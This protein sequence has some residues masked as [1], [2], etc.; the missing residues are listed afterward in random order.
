ME[1]CGT[2]AQVAACLSRSDAVERRVHAVS[3]V[4][5]FE[6][7]EFPLEIRGIPKQDVIE[8]L[9]ADR[10]D[11]PFDKDGMNASLS[12]AKEARAP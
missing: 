8:I 3:V 5:A 7:S 6:G 9:P 11:Q 1:P 10:S 12:D 2:V 4:I